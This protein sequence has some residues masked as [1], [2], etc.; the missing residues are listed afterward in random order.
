MEIKDA[1]TESEE[2]LAISHV[3]MFNLKSH[4]VCMRCVK[5]VG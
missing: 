1:R 2:V 3:I 4:F 5:D